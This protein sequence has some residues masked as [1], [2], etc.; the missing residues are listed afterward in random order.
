MKGLALG[1]SKSASQEPRNDPLGKV[2]YSHSQTWLNVPGPLGRVSSK[3]SP[4]GA[5]LVP[6]SHTTWDVCYDYITDRQEDI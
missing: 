6:A 3:Q 1:A 4:E 5:F 2:C